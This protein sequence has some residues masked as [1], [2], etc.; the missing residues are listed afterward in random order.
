MAG[1]SAAAAIPLLDS[2]SEDDGEA[3][4]VVSRPQ[5]AA[6]GAAEAPLQ[7]PLAA[8]RAGFQ[9]RLIAIDLSG[10]KV[11]ALPAVVNA[12]CLCWRDRVAKRCKT[13]TLLASQCAISLP[14]SVFLF[15]LLFCGMCVCVCTGAV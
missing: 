8:R 1:T 4:E 3:V 11:S 7:P 2:E 5:R 14:F 13:H 6:A 12:V 10:T 15:P 9:L